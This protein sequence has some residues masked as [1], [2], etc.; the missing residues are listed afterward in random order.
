M[1]ERDFHLPAVY[2]LFC[3]EQAIHNFTSFELEIT[4]LIFLLTNVL[5]IYRLNQL[6]VFY[7]VF[8]LY[9]CKNKPAFFFCS[10]Q[11]QHFSEC[12]F[13]NCLSVTKRALVSGGTQ[14]ASCRCQNFFF[15]NSKVKWLFKQFHINPVALWRSFKHSAK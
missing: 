12:W 8:C 14:A 7:L 6:E 10:T 4:R 2:I 9:C 5:S 1:K 15:G 3:D 13:E 11:A